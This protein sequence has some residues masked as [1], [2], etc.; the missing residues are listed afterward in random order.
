MLDKTSN[1]DTFNNSKTSDIQFN[2]TNRNQN[3]LI[4]PIK[5]GNGDATLKIKS[6]GMYTRVIL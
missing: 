1:K 2:S 3:I 6:D 5:Q 4:S